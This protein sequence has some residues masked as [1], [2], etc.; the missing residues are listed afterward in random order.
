MIQPQ[1]SIQ[2][3]DNTGARKVIC[4]RVL[5]VNR[6]QL[7]YSLI[8]VVKEVLPNIS[9]NRS[10]VVRAVMIRT[11]YVIQR[12]SVR[13]CIR[14][15]ESVAVII[16][17]DGNPRGSRIFGPVTRELRNRNFTKIISLA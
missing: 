10:E 3:A 8:V 1:T 5:G 2:V 11:C 9:I 12:N 14:F 17:K 16:N 13:G 6:A 15:N 4:I 7:R